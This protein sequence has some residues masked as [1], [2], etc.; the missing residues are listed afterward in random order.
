[1]AWKLEI[2]V[3]ARVDEVDAQPLADLDVR[4][5]V[6]DQR[7]LGAVEDD[8]GGL[9]VRDRRPV[10]DQW[11]AVGCAGHRVELRLDH[12]ELVLDGRQR[13]GGSTR[14]PPYMPREMCSGTSPKAQ[15]YMKKPG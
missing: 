15:W 13:L 9:L 4:R 14:M 3:E 11:L 10:G 7:A 1:M 5:V 2:E 6:A 12:V 8:V